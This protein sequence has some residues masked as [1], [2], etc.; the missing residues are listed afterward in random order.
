[1]P[2]LPTSSV[3][4]DDLQLE[5]AHL[6]LIDIVGYSKLLVNE[7][8]EI[9]QELGRIVR[10][11]DCFRQAEANRKLIRV[12][13]GDGMALLFFHSPEEP[14]RCALE[15]ATRLK[16]HPKIQVRMGIHSGPINQIRDV[17]DQMNVAGA[18]IN[19]AQRVMDCGDA[20]H[21]LLSKHIADDLAQ[22]GHW[23]PHL[24]DLGE[25]EVKHGFRLQIANLCKDGIG[26]PAV[27][28]K[29]RRGRRWQKKSATV[30]PIKPAGRPVLLGAVSLAVL[31]IALASFVFLRGRVS[32]PPP[33]GFSNPISEKS[34]AVLPFENLSDDKQN[35]YFSDGVQDEIL[36]GLSKVA[37]VKV[38]SRTSVMQYR[39]QTGR[40]LREIAKALGVAHIVE[41]SVQRSGN[42][43]R[44]S[45][46]LINARTDMHLWGEHYDRDLA[47]VFA[48]ESEVA[49]KIV[50][51]LKATISPAEKAAIEDQPTKDLVAYDLYARAK[52]FID[53]F[54]LRPQAKDDLLKAIELLDR[55]IAGDP[56]FLRA[57]C[58]LAQA[59]DS[60]YFLGFDHTAG[61]LDVARKA[62]D[63]AL[64][65]RPDSGEAHLALA[66]HLFSGYRD[67]DG[68]RREISIA[69]PKLP[70]DPQ[71]F[72][73]AG[74][75]DARQG[76]LNEAIKEVERAAD[77]DPRNTSILR[78]L[79]FAYGSA[80]RF[81]SAL[82]V[83]DRILAIEPDDM[84]AQISRAYI[85]FIW[86]AD[87]LPL[88]QT[89]LSILSK[90]PD[91]AP[92]ISATW[93]YLALSE[94]DWPGAEQA[95]SH[96]PKGGCDYSTIPFPDAWCEGLV[97]HFRGDEVAARKAFL[98]AREEI[99]DVL[100][101]QPDYPAGLCVL[102]LTDAALGNKADALREGRRAVEL[103]P[104]TKD[105]TEGALLIQYLALIYTWTGEK[106]LAL[107][108]LEVSAKIP[109][110]LSYGE[111]KMDPYWDS[112]RGD[113]RFEKIVGSLV[114]TKK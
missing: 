39:N 56:T 21:I 17:N 23:R 54:S 14:V 11:T 27:P 30:R 55:A 47:D 9:L 100:R 84:H 67:Y 72:R 48:L 46:Q 16:E 77:L 4:Q 5:I 57:Y 40:N 108:Q 76:R 96:L 45:A 53:A 25:C 73:L 81:E 52:N 78:Q 95:L 101:N 74:S 7:Q 29:L 65:L 49:E 41:G 86:K 80:R 97:A 50:A 24:R 88:H 32:A 106:D 8:I 64:K 113:R 68:A 89:I 36:N 26:N 10:G 20:G 42:R 94:H 91:A 12:P 59:H 87:P 34:I 51:Q 18:G 35:A 102:A 112:L 60:L 58:R 1:V 6:L 19:V 103:C 69:Q 44:V 61:R 107:Q 70:N 82:Q 66:Q 90:N 98:K 33:S 110:G 38:I 31:G 63:A 104:L 28:E 62:V 2:T 85:E 37:D 71:V 43:V 109:N 93:L 114:P 75:I 105:S 92:T 13:T 99:K 83:V 79:Y 3:P 111:L 22:Y 15:I